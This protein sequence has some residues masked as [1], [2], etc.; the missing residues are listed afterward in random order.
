MKP[1]A[2]INLSSV[3]SSV[4]LAKGDALRRGIL[5]SSLALAAAGCGYTRVAAL[6]W[7]AR[8]THLKSETSLFFDAVEYGLGPDNMPFVFHMSDGLYKFGQYRKWFGS[9]FQRDTVSENVLLR[10][11]IK[12]H[13]D[14]PGSLFVLS[15]GVLRL[16]RQGDM[17]GHVRKVAA[18]DPPKLPLDEFK[19][20]VEV[21]GQWLNI[22]CFPPTSLSIHV[23]KP[24]TFGT[25]LGAHFKVPEGKTPQCS[26]I[27]HEMNN[28]RFFRYFLPY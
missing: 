9:A 14:D 18:V 28:M 13:A 19:S 27:I 25:V 16:E 24:G 12:G 11:E 22:E 3:L 21:I 15:N 5:V 6:S 17:E 26:L 8:E 10:F 1:F 2:R 20:G 23:N 4:A 7:T